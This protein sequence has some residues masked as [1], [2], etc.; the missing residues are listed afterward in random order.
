MLLL[1]R[2]LKHLAFMDQ[3]TRHY[4]TYAAGE[5]ILIIVGIL[6]ALQIDNWNEDRK[7]R[8]SLNAHLDTIARNIEEDQRELA[9]L[10]AQRLRRVLPRSSGHF[11]EAR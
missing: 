3:K 1:L 8:I 2:R 6:I 4:L 11:K 5:L 9:E 10:R 7:V